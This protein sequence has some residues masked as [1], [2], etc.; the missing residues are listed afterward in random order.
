MDRC[1]FSLVTRGMQVEITMT[2]HFTH[3]TLATIK[4]SDKTKCQQGCRETGIGC[5][6]WECELM[7]LL[8]HHRHV[9]LIRLS[10]HRSRSILKFEAS[11]CYTSLSPLSFTHFPNKSLEYQIPFWQMLLKT[12]SDS[13]SLENI[14]TLPGKV[15]PGVFYNPATLLLSMAQKNLYHE[16]CT[17]I[18]VAALHQ[19]AKTWK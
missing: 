16:K 15:E 4:W 8:W 13:S 9:L 3:K 17:R 19:I 5:C 2:Y 6:W 7:Q 1:P 11:V 18:F 12:Q 14:F 10:F